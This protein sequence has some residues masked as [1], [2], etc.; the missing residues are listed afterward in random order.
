MIDRTNIGI[1]SSNSNQK[2]SSFIAPKTV[3]TTNFISGAIESN[4]TQAEPF[5]API[6]EQRYSFPQTTTTILPEAIPSYPTITQN[7]L[8]ATN[9]STTVIPQLTLPEQTFTSYIPPITT[10][11][12]P[13][14]EAQTITVDTGIQ[15][16]S[17]MHNT[18][19]PGLSV[20]PEEGI[21][22]MTV[23]PDASVQSIIT[24]TPNVPAPSPLNVVSYIDTQGT[25]LPPHFQ[26]NISSNPLGQNSIKNNGITVPPP[27]PQNGPMAPVMDEDFQRSRPIYDEINQIR[28]SRGIIY[29]H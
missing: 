18:G 23:V 19:I 14:T 28:Y 9:F 15:A 3:E 22:T 24:P 26:K 4:P 10:S 25:A 20:L 27:I 29:G 5:S 7:I 13:T 2:E 17:A 8:P 11:F 21:P 16:L 6:I 12:M 1:T